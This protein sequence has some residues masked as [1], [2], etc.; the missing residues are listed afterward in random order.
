M[1]QVFLPSLLSNSFTYLHF[2]LAT[3]LIPLR[4]SATFH[5]LSKSS[6][7]SFLR[8]NR[9]SGNIYTFSTNISP[10]SQP[11]PCNVLPGRTLLYRRPMHVYKSQ[12][13]LISP[14]P[15]VLVPLGGY[16]PVLSPCGRSSSANL[17]LSHSVT[18]SEPLPFGQQA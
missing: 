17:H 14:S 5:S 1:P 6:T 11:P 18:T 12:F 3:L 7:I 13:F 2:Q 9:F 8:R 4:S 15:F 10:P 16:T